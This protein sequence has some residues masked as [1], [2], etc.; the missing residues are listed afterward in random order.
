[1]GFAHTLRHTCASLLARQ[2]VH[3]TVAADI[4]GHDPAVYLRTYAHLYPEDRALAAAA[5]DAARPAPTPVHDPAAPSE[6]TR[7]R[8][9]RGESAGT[10]P[11]GAK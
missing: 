7:A 9:A 8:S 3:P 1:V 5:L 6:T 11:P 2:G 4:L 10:L